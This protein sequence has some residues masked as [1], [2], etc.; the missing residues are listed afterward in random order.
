MYIV[1][2][3]SLIVLNLKFD[4]GFFGCNIFILFKIEN[5]RND[6]IIRLKDNHILLKRQADKCIQA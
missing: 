4:A 2:V 1:K 5:S 3:R 6:N